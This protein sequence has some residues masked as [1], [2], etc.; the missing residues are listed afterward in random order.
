MHKPKE[1]HQCWR[2]QKRPCFEC[3]SR[4]VRLRG[5]DIGQRRALDRELRA[6]A[7]VHGSK[8]GRRSGLLTPSENAEHLRVARAEVR[9]ESSPVRLL[10]QRCQY[11]PRALT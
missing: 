8:L 6:M 3:T 11:Y 7:A 10:A 2:R 9:R 5:T 1:F 4:L